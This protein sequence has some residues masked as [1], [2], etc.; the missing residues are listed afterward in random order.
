MKI[1]GFITHKP[2]EKYA[3]CQDYFAIDKTKR[4]IAIADGMTQSIFPLEWARLLSQMAIGERAEDLSALCEEW[5]RYAESELKRLQDEGAATWALELCLAERKGAGATLC[6]FYMDR[7]SRCSGQVLGDSCLIEIDEDYRI[8]KFYKSGKKELF[9]Y[10]PEYY[11]VYNGV[12]GN[13]EPIRTELENP[14]CF[15][16]ATDAISEFLYLKQQKQQEQEYVRRLVSVSSHKEFCELVDSWRAEG[17][18][19]DDSTA[20]II[21]IDENPEWELVAVDSLEQLIEEEEN[22]AKESSSVNNSP[23]IEEPQD[24]PDDVNSVEAGSPE[25]EESQ[26]N[27]GDAIDPLDGDYSGVSRWLMELKEWVVDSYRRLK[28]IL[29]GIYLSYKNAKLY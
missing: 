2:A 28:E 25:I 19:N 18:H 27:S 21:E 17:M 23:E 22:N 20:V 12:V 24:N 26:D 5:K 6:S 13:E 1:K 3:D 16:A 4:R 9:D 11:D 29:R 14:K 7:D 8:H 10:R 15:I